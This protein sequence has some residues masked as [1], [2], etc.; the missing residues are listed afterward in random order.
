MGE[1]E[2]YVCIFCG[3]LARTREGLKAHTHIY[4]GTRTYISLDEINSYVDGQMRKMKE[5]EKQGKYDPRRIVEDDP[6]VAQALK[7]KKKRVERDWSS[8]PV[9][10]VK[11]FA[12][13]IKRALDPSGENMKDED[14]V[15]IAWSVLN[16]LGPDGE[17][18]ENFMDK[19]MHKIL[20]MLEDHGLIEF[21]IDEYNVY[22]FFTS[23][24]KWSVVRV[25]LN[26]PEI[27]RL[28]DGNTENNEDSANNDPNE[29]YKTLPE[30]VWS[31][32][33]STN[34]GSG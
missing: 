25:K 23:M 13:A 4:H 10:T 12:K 22:K 28:A 30:E 26:P 15:D 3:A 29:I 8:Y 33:N 24:D 11:T 2:Y 16:F 6:A 14:A 1:D 19:D 7:N 20:Y 18:I 32:R 31:E 27:L 17:I 34:K 9:I 21:E 5:L